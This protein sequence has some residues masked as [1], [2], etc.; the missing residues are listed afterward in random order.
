M[1]KSLS[2]AIIVDRY[3][4]AAVGLTSLLQGQS[5]IAKCTPGARIK[6]VRF[7]GFKRIRSNF[8]R[9]VIRCITELA[10]GVIVFGDCG[11]TD[12]DLQEIG[13]Y[14]FAVLSR[15]I[16]V[17]RVRAAQYASRGLRRIATRSIGFF[18]LCCVPDGN[19]DRSISS[20]HAGIL[21]TLPRQ[22]RFH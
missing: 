10:Q 5:D 18:V 19:W 17:S 7:G 1:P 20:R 3:P 13:P 2:A 14:R 11:A 8:H 6:E 9:V 16:F 15:R 4:T 22:Q 12:A 21:P